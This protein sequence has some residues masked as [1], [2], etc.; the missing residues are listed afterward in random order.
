MSSGS[1]RKSAQVRIELTVTRDGSTRDFVVLPGSDHVL[2]AACLAAAAQWK[3]RPGFIHG[4][5]AN[6]RVIVPF[7]IEPTAAVDAGR[8]RHSAAG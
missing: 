3:F 6:V 2:A 1:A 5:A 7:S 8:A 4:R